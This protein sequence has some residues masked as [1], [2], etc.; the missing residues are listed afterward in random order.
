MYAS[1]INA[2]SNHPLYLPNAN[3][4]LHEW[5]FPFGQVVLIKSN[6]C[7][8]YVL[9]DDEEKIR[10]PIHT[11]SD[12]DLDECIN[13]L[14]SCEPIIHDNGS[15]SFALP[16]KRWKIEEGEVCIVQDTDLLKSIWINPEGLRIHGCA[17]GSFAST[18]NLEK[19]RQLVK[20]CQPIICF[21]KS[22]RVHFFPISHS[23]TWNDYKIE[24]LSNYDTFWDFLDSNFVNALSKDQLPLKANE[25][26]L[27]SDPLFW[28][29]F[30]QKTKQT[31]Y[32]THKQAFIIQNT[33]EISLTASKKTHKFEAF[34]ITKLE[35]EKTSHNEVVEKICLRP[36]TFCSKFDSNVTICVDLWAVTLVNTGKCY[37][38]NPSSWYGHAGLVIEGVK[39]GAYFSYFTDLKAEGGGT[40]RL[41]E[42]RTTTYSG[43]AKTFLV[44]HLKVERMIHT[45]EREI[46]Q[47]TKGEPIVKFSMGKVTPLLSHAEALLK[48]GVNSLSAT[49]LKIKTFDSYDDMVKSILDCSPSILD[50]CIWENLGSQYSLEVDKALFIEMNK[51]RLISEEFAFDLLFGRYFHVAQELSNTKKEIELKISKILKI[52]SK[53]S[54]EKI[55]S[56][57]ENVP[58]YSVVLIDKSKKNLWLESNN[59]KMRDYGNEVKSDEFMA[60]SNHRVVLETE[61]DKWIEVVEPHNCVSWAAVK[62]KHLGLYMGD[63][64]SSWKPNEHANEDGVKLAL[65]SLALSGAIESK[66]MISPQSI[67]IK[68]LEQDKK[69]LQEL[70]QA[71]RYSKEIPQR[72]KIT[73]ESLFPNS[74]SID[75]YTLLWLASIHDTPGV[76]AEICNYFKKVCPIPQEAI[77]SALSVAIATKL[78][79]EIEVLV[80]YFEI[81]IVAKKHYRGQTPIDYLLS[82][83]KNE[84]GLNA[85][86][87]ILMG[88]KISLS[89]TNIFRFERD[90]KSVLSKLQH[91]EYF[92]T[93]LALNSFVPVQE[94]CPGFLCAKH[95]KQ[96][97]EY[98][99][100]LPILDE[101]FQTQKTDESCVLF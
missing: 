87:A 31:T 83:A 61:D 32:L 69:Y 73:L 48:L 95:V 80:D 51:N 23:W 90:L 53:E 26:K 99:E 24:L 79:K 11:P 7:L 13:F 1:K 68:S 59:P 40:V 4:R 39:K 27:P 96:N 93:I 86:L 52:E 42:E 58:Y 56:K 36:I 101:S 89:H 70:Q 12:V 41:T 2:A 78:I 33:D 81:Q 43:K 98:A 60:F 9:E 45:I 91:K 66:Q 20:A 100:N 14:T 75:P 37:S 84:D 38:S 28:H 92:D 94:L 47:Q 35:I 18:Q 25:S 67:R 17:L 76:T 44:S 50:A 62:L 22:T 29:V 49:C 19:I 64:S 15:V 77:I 54:A 72:P 71:L 57:D 10:G 88:R 82:N 3:E 21:R 30:N 6:G 8:E 85:F 55:E 63:F 46:A 16:I 97:T 5:C 74:E 65:S 34:E